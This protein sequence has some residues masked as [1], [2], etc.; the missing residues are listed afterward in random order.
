MKKYLIIAAFFLCTALGAEEIFFE[1][2][3][4]EQIELLTDLASHSLDAFDYQIVV[5]EERDNL[6]FLSDENF[7]HGVVRVLKTS[8]DVI[9][10]YCLTRHIDED[11]GTWLNLLTHFY[12][13]PEFMGHG[14][15]RILF[16]D[17]LYVAKEELHWEAFFWETYPQAAGFYRK[18]GAKQIGEAPS[19][20]NPE[21]RVPIFTYVLN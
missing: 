6:P 17:A 21:Y 4:E 9:G 18:M 13:S 8:S 11:D 10:F 12:V 16:E 15:G 19:S 2:A 14:F 3:T 20:L 1:N 7:Q 5:D